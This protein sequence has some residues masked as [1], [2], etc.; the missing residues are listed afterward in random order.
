MYLQVEPDLNEVNNLNPID[1]DI[2]TRALVQVNFVVQV[3]GG[4][5]TG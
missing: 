2:S 3:T 4:A 1:H 5:K